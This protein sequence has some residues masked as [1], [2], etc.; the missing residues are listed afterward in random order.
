MHESELVA[1]FLLAL[2]ASAEAWWY[3][4][5]IRR[6]KKCSLFALLSD[7][8]Y[9]WRTLAVLQSA[10]AE[11]RKATEELLLEIGARRSLDGQDLWT[12]KK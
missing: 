8:K 1:A 7:G 11:D 2:V 6:I 12:I 5:K 9:E 3:R 10:V 4:R